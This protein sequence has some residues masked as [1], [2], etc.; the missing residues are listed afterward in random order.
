MHD[1]KAIELLTQARAAL[2]ELPDNV[3]TLS[4]RQRI[5]LHIVELP[6]SAWDRHDLGAIEGHLL[7]VGDFGMSTGAEEALRRAL[8]HL[9]SQDARESLADAF[10]ER[11]MRRKAGKGVHRQSPGRYDVPRFVR[12]SL[13]TI[14]A[15]DTGFPE[16]LAVLALE[17]LGPEPGHTQTF[18]RDQLE[19]HIAQ[20]HA[21]GQS[22]AL[23]GTQGYEHRDGV[24]PQDDDRNY[25]SGYSTAWAF[26]EE[27]KTNDVGYG[28]L[29]DAWCDGYIRAPLLTDEEAQVEAKRYA[30]QRAGVLTRPAPVSPPL[31]SEGRESARKRCARDSD[32]CDGI[33]CRAFR[34]CPNADPAEPEPT[35]AVHMLP[36]E[37]IEVGQQAYFPEDGIFREVTYSGP[38]QNG[39]TS[40]VVL[41][42]GDDGEGTVLGEEEWAKSV[43]V[44]VLA[45]A[46]PLPGGEGERTEPAIQV[47]ELRQWDGTADGLRDLGDWAGN[48]PTGEPQFSWVTS[49][50]GE[51]GWTDPMLGDLPIKPDDLFVKVDGWVVPARA[52]KPSS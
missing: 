18:T 10:H 40:T 6:E 15:G 32:W 44:P 25:A 29:C 9:A 20:A 1:P 7:E 24:D 39:L 14:A 30:R 26:D 33:M 37:E 2:N 12:Y 16:K 13:V 23:A 19:R 45:A 46:S 51:K 47:L 11:A 35:F 49:S 3:E 22:A 17:H 36:A 28:A 48:D 50:G 43:N 38:S 42:Y 52:Q 41:G 31:G 27:V 21:D 8:P 5:D 34:D 4:L